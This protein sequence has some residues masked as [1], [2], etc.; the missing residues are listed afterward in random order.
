MNN[1]D[2]KNFA[3]G[4]IYH[5][6]NRGNNKETLFRDKQDYRAFLF[7]LGLVLGIDKDDLANCEI[8]KSPK[9]RIR[10]RSFKP[11][12]FKI[13]AFCLMP[14]HFHI[15]IE[16]CGEESISKLV[17]K[18][19]TS[20]SKYINLKYKRVGQVFQ[21]QFK[22]VYVNTNSQLMLVSSYIHMNPVK[23]RLTESPEKYDWSSFNDFIFDRNNTVVYT[24]FLKE[25]FGGTEQ[26][27]DETIKLYKE[28]MSK[29]PFGF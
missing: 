6:Y 22:S 21:D 10:L 2:Y 19:S 29:M 4:C 26:F 18:L 15:L 17:A 11:N 28:K 12:Y 24:L 5:I 20:F 25:I 13:H 7:R 27:K 3:P 16:Q 1:R 8:I 23:D 14:N 9:S